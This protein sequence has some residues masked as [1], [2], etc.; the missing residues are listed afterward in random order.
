MESVLISRVIGDNHRLGD[1]AWFH[2]LKDMGVWC[3][4][5]RTMSSLREAGKWHLV[6]ESDHVV[7]AEGEPP[8]PSWM[9]TIWD[10][11]DELLDMVV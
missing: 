3:D 7:I 4:I 5:G 11:N 1:V 2:V 6:T 10:E 9:V 8:S